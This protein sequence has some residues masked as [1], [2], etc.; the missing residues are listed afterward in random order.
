MVDMTTFQER[1]YS[2]AARWK[3][4]NFDDSPRTKRLAYNGYI[5]ALIILEYFIPPRTPF[6]CRR[7]YMCKSEPL[8]SNGPQ[9][10]P[11]TLL[12]VPVKTNRAA[13][14]RG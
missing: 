3:A 9:D 6:L 5:Y 1:G 13:F 2:N 14:E 10:S 4:G 12:F 7:E 11:S 8:F